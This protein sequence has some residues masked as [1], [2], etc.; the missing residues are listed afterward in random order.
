M[1]SSM[2]QRFGDGGAVSRVPQRRRP[3][4]NADGGG[5]RRRV[6]R[7]RSARTAHRRARAAHEAIGT[8]RAHDSPG[9]VGASRT[10]CEGA[11]LTEIRPADEPRHHPPRATEIAR[12]LTWNRAARLPSCADQ[13]VRWRG[14]P[15]GRSRSGALPRSS[16]VPRWSP[17]EHHALPRRRSIDVRRS[18][19]PRRAQCSGSAAPAGAPSAARVSR[20]PP[21]QGRVAAP[22]ATL[23]RRKSTGAGVRASQRRWT[24]ARLA[25]AAAGCDA[26][27]RS[28]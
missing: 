10:T 27:R 11:L 25:G 2:R 24:T 20:R 8:F 15:R 3:S 14:R 12:R 23:H 6:L 19:A 17:W 1:P 5:D 28:S 13:G 9:A 4:G 18:H 21:S 7:S 16:P 22:A 26:P